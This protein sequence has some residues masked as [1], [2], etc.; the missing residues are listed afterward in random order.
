MVL[1]ILRS[2]DDIMKLL[3][4]AEQTVT[5]QL[6][7]RGKDESSEM[8]NKETACSTFLCRLPCRVWNHIWS[9]CS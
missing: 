1:L 7:G 4:S 6:I 9:C 2:D 8:A 5:Q 3:V